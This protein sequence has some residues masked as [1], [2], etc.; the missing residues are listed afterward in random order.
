MRLSLWLLVVATCIAGSYSYN[1]WPQ[2]QE[3]ARGSILLTLSPGSLRFNTSSRS[4]LLKAAIARYQT[5]FFPFPYGAAIPNEPEL[6]SV[7]INVASSNELLQLGVNENYTLIVDTSGAVINAGTVFG[8]M[9]ALESLA[10]LI[11]YNITTN[12][13]AIEETPI[14]IFD[15]PRFPWR[16]V[17]IDTGRHY[18]ETETILTMIDALAINKMN[19]LHWHVTDS[20]SFPMQSSKY[21]N[22]AIAGSYQ[23]PQATYSPENVSAIVSYAY[24]RGV[25]VVPE[26]D[27]PGHSYSWGHGYPNLTIDCQAFTSWGVNG[28]TL[29]VTSGFTYEVLDGFIGE[30]RSLFMDNYM[31]F[32]SDEVLYDCWNKTP[33][34][35][36]WMKDNNIP[37]F[38]LLEQYFENNL[39]KIT[40]KNGVTNRVFWED[41]YADHNVS[42]DLGTTTFEVWLSLEYLVRITAAG[43]PVILANGFYLDVQKPGPN[44][45]YEWVDT[46]QDFYSNEPFG[47]VAE[48]ITAAQRALVLGGEACMWGEAVEDENIFSRVWIRASGTAEKLWSSFVYTNSSL[49]DTNF[50]NTENRLI[51]FRC[52]LKRRGIHATA[53][54]PDYCPLP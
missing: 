13:Y 18:L 14:Y 41:A 15:F 20:Q 49:N 50:Q 21:P 32:G 39:A 27:V 2:P 38:E 23:Y 11:D 42:F 24:E 48:N 12:T 44:I 45:H 28:V 7:T 43:Y 34:V 37:S 8:A 19:T 30:M 4:Q 31:H 52:R 16:G 22:L 36:Q 47:G 17:M 53:L 40:K 26:F 33:A 1:V 51:E 9:H 6:T 3:F 29:D 25:R 35:V 10:Q 46:W 54:R 5:A